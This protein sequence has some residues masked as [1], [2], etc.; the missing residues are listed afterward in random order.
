MESLSVLILTANEERN[1]AKCLESIA[2]LGAKVYIVDSF[3]EDRTVEIARS[4]GATVLQNPW[5]CYADQFNWGLDHA[6]IDTD[7]VMRMDA[8]EEIMPDLATAI[9]DFLTAPP[10]DV[11]GVYVRRR[12]YFMGRWIRHGGYYPTWL[13]R[14]FRRGVGRVEA[15]WMDEHIVL[16]HGKTIEIKKDIIDKN[17]KDLAF[18]TDKHNRYSTCEVLDIVDSRRQA[19]AGVIEGE[20]AGSQA[21]ARRWVKDKVYSRMPLFLRPLLY[22]FYRYFVRLGFLDGKEGLIFHFLQGFWYRFLVDAKLY[23]HRKTLQAGDD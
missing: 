1:I 13:L 6:G 10:A 3:S 9:C 17:N 5:T 14:V 16:D 7:W 18:W 19:A 21:S 4:M 12:V 11:A 15:L 2:P 22:Y 23:E 8:D 20:L